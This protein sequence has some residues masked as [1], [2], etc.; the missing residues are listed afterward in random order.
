MNRIH[1][2]VG[3]L[4]VNIESY[5]CAEFKPAGGL[6]LYAEARRTPVCFV[7][8]L[9]VGLQCARP[10]EFLDPKPYTLNPKP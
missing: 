1:D 6:C 7:F 4:T 8:F 3:A 10:P 2:S 9:G 5:V